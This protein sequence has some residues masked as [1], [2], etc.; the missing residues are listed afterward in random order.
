MK[1]VLFF[2]LIF[3]TIPYLSAQ[4][5]RRRGFPEKDP[6]RLYENFQN[7]PKGYGNV[8]FYWWQGD[9]LK[10]ERLA[11]Q[12]EILSE[13]AIDGFAV[14][15]AHT[16]PRVDTE[17]AKNGYGFAGNTEP[18]APEIFSEQWWD[19]W[20][21]YSEECAKHNLG[22]GL[23]DYT[24]GWP[25][26]GY[27]PDQIRD[28]PEMKAHQG[29]LHIETIEVQGGSQLQK[30]LPEH[31]LTAVAWPGKM[32]LDKHIRSG[33]LQWEAPKGSDY[34]VY[35]INT[36]TGFAIHPEYGKT[37]VDMYF[38]EF[39]K[40]LTPEEFGG[41]N[42]FFQDELT[43]PISMLSWSDGF[44]EEFEKR[45]GYDILPYLPALTDYIGAQTPKI[46]LDYCEVLLD[47]AEERYFEPIYKWHADRELIYGSDN[48]GRGKEP[49]AYVDYFR[50]NSWYTAPGNDAPARGSSF[51]ETKVSSSISHLYD[52]PRTWLEAFHSMGWGSTGAWLTEQIDHHFIAGGNLVCMHGLYYSTHGGWW[53]W[54]PPCFHFRMPYWPHMIKWLEYTQRMS[55]ILSQGT[56]VCDI[57]LMYPTE[58]MQAYPDAD[59]S[60]AFDLA[61]RLS[62]HGLDYD[63]MHY[64]PL[65]DA[66]TENGNLILGDESYK[67]LILSD[68][69]ACHHSTL[70]K[71]LE[72][73]RNGGIVLAT[74]TLPQATTLEGENSPAV[75]E[76]L[77]ELFSG[78]GGIHPS[79]GKAMYLQ[80]DQVVDK[81]WEL[82]VPDFASAQGTGKVLHRKIG[83]KDLYMITNVEKNDICFFRSKGRAELWDASDGSKKSFPVL[84][85]DKNGTYLKVKK[86]SNQSYLIV[87]SPGE[88]E[89][90]VAEK[91]FEVVDRIQL[92]GT[93]DIEYLP[94][95]NNKWGDYRLP[96]SDEMIGP[97]APVFKYRKAEANGDWYAPDY[98][99]SAWR[100]SISGYGIQAEYAQVK[101]D[102]DF[103]TA[104]QRVAKTAFAAWQPY[105]FS[106][107]HGVWFN[108]GPQGFHGLKS[109][110]SNGFFILNNGTHEFYRTNVWVPE[111][112]AYRIIID[113]RTPDLL[114]LDQETPDTRSPLVLSK[115]WLSLLAGYSSTPKID[116]HR[117]P[118]D[119]DP[120]QRSMVV[121]IPEGETVP[122]KTKM[123]HP[124]VSSSW[125][126]TNHLLYSP[127]TDPVNSWQFRIPTVPGVKQIELEVE[128]ELVVCRI[129]GHEIPSHK[130]SLVNAENGRKRY[131]ITFPAARESIETLALE[132][133]AEHGYQGA[134]IIPAPVKFG[135]ETGKLVPGNW[136][137][138]GSLRYYS[139]G[140]FYRKTLDLNNR[141]NDHIEIDLGN[142][143]AT[144]EV[145]INGK[146]AGI[147]MSPPYR[148]DITDYA[149]QGENEVEIL[150]Y[151]TLSNHYQTIPSTYMGAPDAGLIGP[152]TVEISK[153]V[154]R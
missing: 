153:T 108:P 113:G 109:R 62:E 86:Q 144:C 143:I 73:Y 8:P 99:D 65:R 136:A 25:N 26:N 47:L 131:N 75:K 77:H 71:A 12:L 40:R 150:V 125:A 23:D 112:G 50:A 55:Y 33:K 35:L 19:I 101:A 130:I 83:D 17:M 134:A 79:G 43:Y 54:A 154:E 72:H 31:F 22:V 20:K 81:V 82:I 117:S 92:A 18:G 147:L 14:S 48:H 97:E 145:K 85:T 100:E 152:V 80:P 94:T 21:W 15:Y 34:K 148:L 106:W 133:H 90:N 69:R 96:A 58:S 49:L 121:L 60:A 123:Y 53:E 4:T 38:G 137:E 45:K 44:R 32:V 105:E 89:R 29:T 103:N 41:L 6:V 37:L 76:I 61:M 9:S 141:K 115:G 13:A 142:V 111:D 138:Q 135:C 151:S 68:L 95:L 93:W 74:G 84:K 36:E 70:L 91:P 67:V 110:V 122:E 28:L 59:A 120:R 104:A 140:M 64:K 52:R 10:K 114:V 63:F 2:L 16:D 102:T 78:N 11:E 87:F 146:S 139:G 118:F 57:A 56:H 98:D 124:T 30:E 39:E 51:L 42:Y 129:S 66:K 24:F 128:G 126:M 7:P 88:P 107:Q 116:Y 3:T 132:I 149:G 1:R 5:Q 127:Y 119:D 27:F 46:R